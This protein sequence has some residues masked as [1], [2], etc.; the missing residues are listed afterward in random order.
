MSFTLEKHQDAQRQVYSHSRTYHSWQLHCPEGIGRKR[1]LQWLHGQNEMQKVEKLFRYQINYVCA[2][3][4]IWL[5]MSC[6]YQ[7]CYRNLN[8]QIADVPVTAQAK[9]EKLH[10]G[11]L[12]VIGRL[13]DNYYKLRIT[14]NVQTNGRKS[15]TYLTNERETSTVISYYSQLSLRE[16][17]R[18]TPMRYLDRVT[19]WNVGYIVN[20]LLTVYSERNALREETHTHNNV[21]HPDHDTL[22]LSLRASR[23]IRQMTYFRYKEWI[24]IL[25]PQWHCSFSAALSANCLR[26]IICNCKNCQ[27]RC[28]LWP[29]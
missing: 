7:S 22:W 12:K 29:E 18:G 14:I 10:T 5:H 13:M 4:Y 1:A 16:S 11:I 26:S 15:D 3:L 27:V 28:F 6:C 17:N 9:W 21:Q 8:V 24:R 2:L 25:L 23:Y 19:F 20:A